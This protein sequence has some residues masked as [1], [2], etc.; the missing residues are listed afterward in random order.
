MDSVPEDHHAKT[1]SS[2]HR[3][4]RQHQAYKRSLSQVLKELQPVANKLHISSSIF[5]VL[6]LVLI[7]LATIAFTLSVYMFHRKYKMRQQ[8]YA[9]ERETEIRG[10]SVFPEYR[11]RPR[12]GDIPQLPRDAIRGGRYGWNNQNQ[13]DLSNGSGSGEDTLVE[14]E[15]VDHLWDKSGMKLY[16]VSEKTEEHSIRHPTPLSSATHASHGQHHQPQHP[17]QHDWRTARSSTS[18]ETTQNEGY[19]REQL[20]HLAPP[21]F[22]FTNDNDEEGSR[23][24]SDQESAYEDLYDDY[25]GGTDRDSMVSPISYIGRKSAMSGHLSVGQGKGA[26]KHDSTYSFGG[27]VDMY[28]TTSPS[29]ERDS[30]SPGASSPTKGWFPR[31]GPRNTDVSPL[32]PIGNL[33]RGLRKSSIG[34]SQ[35]RHSPHPP[36]IPPVSIPH[37]ISPYYGRGEHR[38]DSDAILPCR[39]P[40]SGVPYTRP[41]GPSP[42]LLQTRLGQALED[43]SDSS[44]TSTRDTPHR[45][46]YEH[47]PAVMS[48][49]SLPPLIPPVSLPPASVPYKPPPMPQDYRTLA[50]HYGSIR[51]AASSMRNT[52]TPASSNK[53]SIRPGISPRSSSNSNNPSTRRKLRGISLYGEIMRMGGGTGGR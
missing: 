51:T 11:P 34:R 48:P 1:S 13:M 19:D 31:T 33:S 17:P 14:D 15:L 44:L 23:S 5:L 3:I 29:F 28:T 40:E 46:Q 25:Y 45:D 43:S 8:T 47:N 12:D 49:R 41:R 7:T 42:A 24:G 36:A 20:P 39:L 9:E 21:T 32:S 37:A 27:L 50:P 26:D 30:G 35:L 18:S 22:R 52:P 4:V 6:I 10:M 38:D 53:S 16:T 2:P